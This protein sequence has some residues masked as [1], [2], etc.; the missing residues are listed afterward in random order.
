ME[1]ARPPHVAPSPSAR[2][3]LLEPREPSPAHLEHAATELGDGELERIAA[4]RFPSETYPTLLDQ[5]PGVGV[6]IGEA[7]EREERGEVDA[8]LHDHVRGDRDLRDLLGEL[9]LAVDAVEPRLGGRARADPLVQVDDLAGEPS[10]SPLTTRSASG[11][12]PKKSSVR[13]R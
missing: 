11:G 2:I 1:I 8:P 10:A 9:A 13:S 7:E 12:S 4:H 5:P 6:R 3:P